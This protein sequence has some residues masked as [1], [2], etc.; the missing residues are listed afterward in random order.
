[1]CCLCSEVKKGREG[2]REEWK[3]PRLSM[4]FCPLPRPPPV[5]RHLLLP[6][7]RLC[8]GTKHEEEEEQQQQHLYFDLAPYPP[9]FPTSPPLAVPENMPALPA[10]PHSPSSDT[11]EE[12]GG[13]GRD[14]GGD[15][16]VCGSERERASPALSYSSSSEG[17][18]G[19]EGGRNEWEQG[20]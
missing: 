15:E 3:H 14:E 17:E 16:G 4:S 18:G 9:S 7:A 5:I 12:E 1:M 6:L 8:W 20:M 13:E 19:R 11:Q 10:L 2:G